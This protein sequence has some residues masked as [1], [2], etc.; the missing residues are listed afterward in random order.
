M[1]V[2]IYVC[3]CSEAQQ[4]MKL[5][6]YFLSLQDAHKQ[7]TDMRRAQSDHRTRTCEQMKERDSKV[8]NK[9]LDKTTKARGKRRKM[10]EIKGG[11]RNVNEK[12]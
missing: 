9:N 5:H 11:G 10:H 3:V 6:I 1:L 4:L 2:Y 7:A 12:Q 8:T